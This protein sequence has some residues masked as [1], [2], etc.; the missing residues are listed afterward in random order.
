MSQLALSAATGVSTRHLSYVEN[1]RSRASRVLVVRLAE[2]L[3]VPIDARD[4]LFVAAGHAPAA[5]APQVDA[6]TLDAIQPLLDAHTP[7]PALVLD[8][9]WNLIRA[10]AVVHRVLAPLPSVLRE[11]RL[12]LLRATLHPEGLAALVENLPELADHL[13]R[14]VDRQ[15]ER[16]A[17]PVLGELRREVAGYLPAHD[18][19]RGSTPTAGVD[20]VI[21]MALRTP[22]G[23]VRLISAT[24][25][26]GLPGDVVVPGLA[27]EIFYP[28]D[29]AAARWLAAGAFTA[30][31]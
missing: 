15:L 4:A 26:V 25:V 3:G 19:R 30:P 18:G 2:A 6:A 9:R 29:E 16:T 24:S 5:R 17:D 21:P 14:R 8:A 27:L 23:T 1:G 7:N 13:L 11:P 28:A 10:N 31:G 20:V 22:L 12:N